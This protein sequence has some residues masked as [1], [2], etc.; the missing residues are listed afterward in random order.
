MENPD[1]RCNKCHILQQ[2][3]IGGSELLPTAINYG[4]RQAIPVFARRRAIVLML[5]K[6]CQ[7]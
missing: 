2:F 1:W 5:R 7:N 6:K 3:S 4:A